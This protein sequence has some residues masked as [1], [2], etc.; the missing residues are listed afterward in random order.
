MRGSIDR[1]LV[2]VGV[3]RKKVGRLSI[4]RSMDGAHN[5]A[6]HRLLQRQM[7]QIVRSLDGDGHVDN[8]NAGVEDVDVD[9]GCHLSFFFR[10]S[11]FPLVEARELHGYAELKG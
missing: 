7:I 10:S 6:H 4:M 3:E 9:H 1:K 5:M 2:L 11:E 8:K